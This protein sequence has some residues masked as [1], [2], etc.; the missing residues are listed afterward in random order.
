LL[1]LCLTWFPG[2]AGAATTFC[3]DGPPGGVGV[4]NT[5]NDSVWRAVLDANVP[6]FGGGAL[7]NAR[8]C[9]T[10]HYS[11]YRNSNY[12]RLSFELDVLE[13]W[14]KTSYFMPGL[15][16][17]HSASF[18]MGNKTMPPGNWDTGD[19]YT[20]AH[21]QLKSVL[22]QWLGNWATCNAKTDPK[23]VADCIWGKSRVVITNPNGWTQTKCAVADS[24]MGSPQPVG[25]TWTGAGGTRSVSSFFQT[26]CVG[27]HKDLP[28]VQFDKE[29]VIS[30]A[31][32]ILLRLGWQ[33]QGIPSPAYGTQ[34]PAPPLDS[35]NAFIKGWLDAA[36]C[37]GS[38]LQ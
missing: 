35:N 26:Y 8:A 33:R 9:T 11:E 7:G 6:A 5:Y 15:T 36:A 31:D 14:T 27:C 23:A 12:M 2:V 30:H 17:A 18:R 25:T 37:Q 32:Q 3:G 24:C 4:T 22:D 1:C 34:M 28:L 29:S 21:T 38:V 20:A 19:A 10:C 13:E 16:K